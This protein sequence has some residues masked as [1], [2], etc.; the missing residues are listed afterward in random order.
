MPCDII[1]IDIFKN[2]GILFY[3]KNIAKTHFMLLVLI[4]TLQSC[5]HTRSYVSEKNKTLESMK[6]SKGNENFYYDNASESEVYDEV[7][8]IEDDFESDLSP[9][10]N[11]LLRDVLEKNAIDLKF[12]AQYDIPIEINPQVIYFIRYFQT[13]G[14]RHFD[15]WL[16]RSET[17][18]PYLRKILKKHNMPEDL[19]FVSMIESG[20]SP[21]AYSRAGAAGPWQF[22]KST[23]KNYGLKI[24]WWIDERRNLE[25]STVAAIKYLKFLHKKFDSWYLA[26]AAYNAGEG[27]IE[28]AI[29]KYKTRNYWELCKYRYIRAETKN[30]VP[31]MIAAALIVKNLKHYGF[32]EIDFKT[33][34]EHKNLLLK[35][36]TDLFKVAKYVETT[37]KH[38]KEINPELIRWSTPPKA[39]DYILKLPL[40]TN[41]DQINSLLAN[42]EKD[43]T[44]FKR[45]IVRYG[46]TLW[47]IARKYGTSVGQ[48]KKMNN[49][50]R[51]N[52]IRIGQSLGI[53]VRANYIPPKVNRKLAATKKIG[54]ASS[55]TIYQTTPYKV[56]K[57]DTIWTIASKYNISPNSLKS[58]NQQL[59]RKRSRIYAGEIIQVPMLKREKTVT[60]L[61]LS[62]SNFVTHKVRRGETLTFIAKKYTTSINELTALNNLSQR[63][64]IH[65]GDILK[66][67]EL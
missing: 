39:N 12:G 10:D 5:Q 18:I 64:I 66:V 67:R 34:P 30:Y 6:L 31:K 32:S 51:S 3:L 38:L 65:P 50:A 28:R 47:L 15:K 41:N 40:E 20:F 54:G 29:K 4:F 62:N 44:Q 37:Y 17:Y 53:P 58:Y 25:K 52:R 42:L 8:E 9:E 22:M 63:S 26:I 48:I 7:V 35:K 11:D 60:S 45:H 33:L 46:E 57:G 36:P 13:R 1:S 24:N 55:E 43:Q 16:S 56:R 21:R 19:V 59:K 23:G 14:K 2:G 49:L 27:K 61:P